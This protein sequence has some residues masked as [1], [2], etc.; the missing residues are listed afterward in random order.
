MDPE[1]EMELLRRRDALLA[2]RE[3][4]RHRDALL[5]ERYPSPYQGSGGIQTTPGSVPLNDA[6]QPRQ[7]TN[8]G[9]YAYGTAEELDLLKR[10]DKQAYMHAMDERS[11]RTAQLLALSAMSTHPAVGP[12]TLLR[13]LTT[14]NK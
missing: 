14:E 12:Q 7:A 9:G 5:A 11:R 10:R 8:T 3:L 4:L 2:E 6:G 1:E 13:L